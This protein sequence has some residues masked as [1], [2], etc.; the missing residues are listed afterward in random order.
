MFT[1]NQLAIA[2]GD[3]PV[4]GPPIRS[5]A[6]MNRAELRTLYRQKL[7]QVR[8]DRGQGMPSKFDIEVAN[9]IFDGLVS[10]LRLHGRADAS[11]NIIDADVGSGKTTCAFA[12]IAALTE[13]AEAQEDWP[14]AGV[15]Y[16]CEQIVQCDAAY[17][18][19]SKLLPDQVAVWSKEHDPNC[20][21][22]ER[23]Q[24]PADEFTQ[25]ELIEYPVI[26]VTH[27]FLRVGGD[28]V[29]LWND[30]DQKRY[31]ALTIID[32]R[33]EWTDVFDLTI[34]QAHE[35]KEELVRQGASETVNRKVAKLCDLMAGYELNDQNRIKI[36]ENCDS[37][38]WFTGFEA[39]NAASRYASIA[40]L[41]DLFSFAKALTQGCAFSAPS[42]NIT[43][44]VGWTPAFEIRPGSVLLDATALLDAA[45]LI[46]SGRRCAYHGD[47]K[48]DALEIIHV[49]QH[50]PA[51]LGSFFL[52]EKNRESYV[53]HMLD[54]IRANMEPGEKGL[55]VAKMNL[56]PPRNKHLPTW[57]R[58]DL[59][60]DDPASYRERFEWDLDGRKLCVTH[61]GG[62]GTGQ[63]WWR[64]ADV[65]FLFDEFF[66]PRRTA[67]AMVQGLRHH[68]ADEGEL[69]KLRTLRDASDDIDA[70]VRGHRRCAT[71]QMALRGKARNIDG[72]GRCAKQR[73]VV[74]CNP[75]GF[76]AEAARLFPG[77]NVTMKG[78]MDKRRIADEI[79][80][81]L[82]N[83]DTPDRISGGEMG[84]RLGGA[85]RGLSQVV[86]PRFC[87]QLAA[88]GW[89]YIRVRGRAGSYFERTH[90]PTQI[91]PSVEFDLA[92]AA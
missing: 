25:D 72:D 20:K 13:Y 39:Q 32:E 38:R 18:E 44:F 60:W 82:V 12:F 3:N 85:W 90:K 23:L 29:R 35:I 31:R 37:V 40:G 58:N 57:E 74:S 2:F 47:V 21:N 26:V 6:G 77:A 50:T 66:I 8:N 89:R 34:R 49:P 83:P 61:W 45:N 63:N 51:Q 87:G 36:I 62:P 9:Q 22:R 16:S 56:M 91:P 15:I 79:L 55:V 43:H 71:K 59:R 70:I 65:V 48:Y 64:D 30:D 84:E 1:E 19:L 14:L 68:R 78:G 76:L 4:I 92:F 52:K 88:I 17:R 69:A 75:D 11:L 86:T 28:K 80:R 33:P 24:E 54:V 10:T 42:G 5:V 7:L 46:G 81:V 67:A 53:K 41:R 27:E 73:L